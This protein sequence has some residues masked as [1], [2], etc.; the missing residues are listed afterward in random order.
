MFPYLFSK[1]LIIVY[2]SQLLKTSHYNSNY[3]ICGNSHLSSLRLVFDEAWV[4]SSLSI[5]SGILLFPYL[6]SK[7]LIIVYISQLLKTSH[8][9]SNYTIR[10]N[11]HL[12]SLRLVFDEA[13]VIITIY[14]TRYT[15][16]SVPVFKVTYYCL[17]FTTFKNFPRQ[18]TAIMK[19]MENLTFHHYE[20]FSMDH[21]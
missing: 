15:F 13:W 1:L 7:L 8:Y 3:T 20:H 5:S 17:H 16:V 2:I 4:L 9:N 21:P 12:S 19:Y 11:S 6:F 14:F 18:Q 10:G